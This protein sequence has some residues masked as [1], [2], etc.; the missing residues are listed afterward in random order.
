[1]YKESNHNG[2]VIVH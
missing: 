1:M 2:N